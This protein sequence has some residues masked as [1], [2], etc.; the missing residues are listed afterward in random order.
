MADSIWKKGDKAFIV[1]PKPDR[2]IKHI[3][4]EV[5]LDEEWVPGAWRVKWKDTYEDGEPADMEVVVDEQ[6]LFKAEDSGMGKAVGCYLV[7]LLQ[8]YKDWQQTQSKET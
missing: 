2:V 4:R 7:N 1:T 3:L 8:E 5:T 6:W